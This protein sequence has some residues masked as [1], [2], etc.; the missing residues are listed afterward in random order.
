MT[1]NVSIHSIFLRQ[2]GLKH[3]FEKGRGRH[4]LVILGV[5]DRNVVYGLHMGCLAQLLDSS[6]EPLWARM[7][8]VLRQ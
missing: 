6:D 3:S 1:L 5:S 8:G 7:Q 2:I 4:E